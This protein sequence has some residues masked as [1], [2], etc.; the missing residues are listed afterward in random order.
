MALITAVIPTQRRFK[1]IPPTITSQADYRGLFRLSTF[2]V[3][4]VERPRAV[5]SNELPLAGRQAAA[6]TRAVSQS[7]RA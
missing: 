1:R 7:T 4:V 5:G 6:V 3:P 2:L